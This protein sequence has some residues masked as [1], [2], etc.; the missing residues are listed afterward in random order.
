MDD[1]CEAIAQ[2]I[3]R[4]VTGAVNVAEPSPR[5]FRE[6]LEMTAARMRS[7]A[8]SSRCRSRQC[9]PRCTVER[10]GLPSP[11]RSESLLGMKGLRAVAVEGDLERLGVRVRGVEE[12][13]AA[14]F[15][16]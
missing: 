11:R 5:S 2:A 6:V 14:I 4:D 13:L 10:I 8:C 9:W 3:E 15:S 12:S 7:A 16:R 1:L